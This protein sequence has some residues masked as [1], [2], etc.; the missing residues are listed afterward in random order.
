MR[1]RYTLYLPGVLTGGAS[2]E[3]LTFNYDLRTLIPVQYRE[4]HFLLTSEFHTND[5]GNTPHSGIAVSFDM[6][7]T[8]NQSFPSQQ[9]VLLGVAIP[10]TS[11]ND[12]GVDATFCY[13]YVESCSNQKMINYPEIFPI[14]I[15]VE[16]VNAENLPAGEEFSLTLVFEEMDD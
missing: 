10:F 11:S 13:S 2:E 12:N 14:K 8:Y 9:Y 3:T 4:K 6:P 16:S 7:Q 1:K 5:Y 15:K